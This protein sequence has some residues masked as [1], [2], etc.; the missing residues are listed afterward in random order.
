MPWSNWHVGDKSKLGIAW[1]VRAYPTYILVDEQ[2][3]I[4]VRTNGISDAFLALVEDAVYGRT[5]AMARD[6]TEA[7]NSA[8]S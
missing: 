5:P 7:S 3:V 2:G 4:L 8:P 6:A 1:G